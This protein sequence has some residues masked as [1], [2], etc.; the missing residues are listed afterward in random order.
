MK[1]SLFSKEN[2]GRAPATRWGR[3]SF[4]A[5][6]HATLEVAEEDLDVLRRLGWLVEGSGE[7]KA[8]VPALEPVVQAPAAETLTDEA[9]EDKKKHA[10]HR[11]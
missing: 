3:V 1:V 7:A 10:K 6:G 4:D 8:S 9:P 5:S 2:A 11:R